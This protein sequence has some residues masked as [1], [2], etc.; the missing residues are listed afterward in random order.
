MNYDIK[1]KSNNKNA[2]AIELDRIS[3]IAHDTKEI[4]TK[5]LMLRIHGTSDLKPHAKLKNS[6]DIHLPKLSSSKSGT[7]MILDCASF[8][9]NIELL[10]LEFFDSKEEIF[11]LTP[12]ALVIQ[13]F[14]SALIETEDKE[15]LDRHLLKSLLKFKNNF[16][17]SDE[18]F[19]FS[20]RGTIAEIEIKKSDFKKIEMLEEK[21]PEPKKSIVNG[22]L[23]EMRMS[24]CRIGLLTADGLVSIIASDKSMMERLITFMG[25]EITV[26][27]M[28]H[29]KTNGQL[30]YIEI[31]EFFE[32]NK[33]DVHF[34]KKPKAM[35]LEQQVLFSLKNGKKKNP[36]KSLI[37][38]W[39]GDETDEEFEK[40][41]KDL[42]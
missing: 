18:V 3:S 25:K 17:D 19:Y 8:E 34:S 6:L 42:D 13:S 35:S 29:Y 32:A 4:A 27:G 16:I 33:S 37:G 11:K 38:K 36:L 40:L 23:D 15:Y 5:A 10:Q 1:I 21:I 30:S 14:R 12:M 26:S 24:K 31:I 20:N 39:S 7:E 28:S 9:K 2:S 41:L 22:K